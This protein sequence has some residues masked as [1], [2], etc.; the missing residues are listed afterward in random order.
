MGKPLWVKPHGSEIAGS[1]HTLRGRVLRSKVISA[2]RRASGSFFRSA[3]AGA[4]MRVVGVTS[5]STLANMSLGMAALAVQLLAAGIYSAAEMFSP[6]RIRR[7]V[8][9]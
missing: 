4:G 9:A 7:T 6:W 5:K 3:I 1:P 8:S 2:G